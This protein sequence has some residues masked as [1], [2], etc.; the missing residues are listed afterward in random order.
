M[1]T[2]ETTKGRGGRPA[3][4]TVITIKSGPHKGQLQGIITLAD[5]SRKRLPPFPRGTSKAMAE[6]RTLARAQ[7]AQAEGIKKPIPP[8]PVAPAELAPD[9]PMARWIDA[10]NADRLARGQTSTRDNLA[11]YRFHILPSIG[12]RHVRDWTREDLRKL[13][14]DL[15]GKV[16]AREISWKTATNAWG[17]ATKMSADAAESKRDEIRCRSENP[18]AGVRG[19]DRGDESGLQFLNPSEFLRF[20]SCPEVPLVWR[21]LVA[22]AVY[23]YPRDGELRVFLCRDADTAH[24]S[25]SITKA[26]DKSTD[27]VKATKGRRS[28]TVPI[29]PTL[30][31]LLEAMKAGRQGDQPLVPRFPSERDMARGLRRYLWKAGVRRHEL[32]YRTPTT[33]PIRFHDLRATGI[34]WLAVRGDDALKIQARAGHRELE[35][36][37]KYIRLAELLGGEAFG[38]V[39]S[40]LPP[41]LYESP[42]SEV[43]IASFDHE[44]V[45]V[46]NLSQNL[47]GGRDSNPRPPA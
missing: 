20:V 25:A 44:E 47:R 28:R 9:S 8:G 14:R 40:A 15:D 23:L 4:G 12:P 42:A 46:Q 35:T 16:R 17:T 29:E 34:T 19:P 32:H 26:R 31:A 2:K 10:W 39:F 13:S 36:T 3:T 5:G 41:E 43:S 22:V 33:R 27:E 24:L 37:Q 11:H 7:Q 6:E 21:R 30:V 45:T 1:M 38:E 18:A